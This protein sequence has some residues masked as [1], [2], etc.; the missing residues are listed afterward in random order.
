MAK[1]LRV[2]INGFGRIGTMAFRVAFEHHRDT[3]EVV[4]VNDLSTAELSAQTL[5]YDSVY[6]RFPHTVEHDEN[7]ITVDGQKMVKLAEKDPTQ[8]PWKEMEIDVVLE[9]T[10][11]FTDKKGAGQHLT[12]GAKGVIISAPGKGDEPIPTY[13]LGVNPVNSGETVISNASCTTN[14]I[15]PVMK[16][17]EDTFGIEKSMMSTIHGYTADQNL[18]DGIHK[19]PRRARSA[20]LNI[21]PTTTGAAIATT[22][23]IPSLKGKFDGVAFRVPV[24]VG[25][26]SDITAILKRDVTIEE[27]NNALKEAAASDAFKGILAVT[28]DPIVSSDIIGNPVS[29]TVDLQLT[30]V[31]GG[32]MVKVVSW[33]DNEFGYSN[34]LIE[35]A[36][37]FGN[38]L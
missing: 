7:S 1:K 9:C 22:E 38:I 5:Q 17:L 13:V 35:Q 29:S 25:S 8:L 20:A 18:V 16:V 37:A 6:R 11:V 28:E 14:C 34:R 2:A 30:N 3:V 4:A 24:P 27:V 12:A 26:C 36:V 21:V 10:G 15:A 19:D 32:N 33:Y 23:T 31:V